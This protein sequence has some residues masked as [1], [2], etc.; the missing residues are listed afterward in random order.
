MGFKN[1]HGF[2]RYNLVYYIDIERNPYNYGPN[3]SDTNNNSHMKVRQ[4]IAGFIIVVQIIISSNNIGHT[5][6]TNNSDFFVQVSIKIFRYNS[7]FDI[8]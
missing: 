3:N 7:V 5:R 6:C 1:E 2:L 8:I 4:M